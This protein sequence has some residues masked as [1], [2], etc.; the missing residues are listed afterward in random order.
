MSS[1]CQRLVAEIVTRPTYEPITVEQAKKQVEIATSN[2]T[3][4]DHLHELIQSARQQWEDHTDTACCTQTWQVTFNGIFDEFPLP[5]RPI[6]SITSIKYYDGDN[7]LTTLS[8][9]VYQLDTAKRMVR[10]AYN[11][12]FPSTIG[13]W[14]D[15][16]ITYVAGYGTD[17]TYV[18]GVAKRAMLLHIGY[19]FDGNR[20]DND[21]ASDMGQ[22]EK[23]VARYIRSTYP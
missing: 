4:E 16:K 13:R 2:D 23:L 14:D 15:W 3:H 6:Q 5:R 22:Y 9:S 17:G 8:S 1:T 21:K 12:S 7:V 20:G 19:H 18:P 10:L 11:Q